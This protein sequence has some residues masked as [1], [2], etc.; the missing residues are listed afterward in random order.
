M[1]TAVG[2]Y[3]PARD[4]NNGHCA[5]GSTFCL[6]QASLC[7][8]LGLLHVWQAGQRGWQANGTSEGA[9]SGNGNMSTMLAEY[10]DIGQLHFITTA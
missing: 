4:T 9:H 2:M 1:S 7:P 8:G 3:H 6:G 5:L 10:R